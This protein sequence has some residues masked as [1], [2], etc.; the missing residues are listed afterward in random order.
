MQLN[1]A[2]SMLYGHRISLLTNQ[3]ESEIFYRSTTT[4]PTID[5][6][7]NKLGF[8]LDLELAI[9]N[10]G[11]G[12]TQCKKRR[13]SKGQLAKCRNHQRRRRLPLG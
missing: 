9:T 7:M 2:E 1:D 12:I 5:S 11:S 10:G 8:S 6:N 13:M 3:W 4:A